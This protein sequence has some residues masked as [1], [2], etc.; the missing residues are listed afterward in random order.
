MSRKSKQKSKGRAKAYS[1]TPRSSGKG[2]KAYQ[3]A[4]PNA[5]HVLT[6]R[7]A[8][9]GVMIAAVTGALALAIPYGGNYPV[10]I[11]VAL[12]VLGFITGLGLFAAIRAREVAERFQAA[13]KNVQ[14]KR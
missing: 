5:Q 6:V 2:A 1:S 14:R 9:I 3:K 12:V 11:I 4:G 8:G 10:G 7:L 13:R